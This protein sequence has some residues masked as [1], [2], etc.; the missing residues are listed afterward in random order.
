MAARSLLDSN[1]T[2]LGFSSEQVIFGTTPRMAAVRRCV[3]KVASA[4]VPVLLIGESGTGKD[5]IARYIHDA[6]PW[7]SGAFV[8]INCPAIPG[9]LIESELFGYEQGG[10]TGANTAK[11]GRVELAENGTLFLD[12]ISELDSSVQSKLLQ[13]LQD[14]KFCRIGASEDKQ[15][16]VRLVCA[17]NRNLEQEVNLGN[18]RADLFYRI[19][20]V[21]I[22]LPPLRERSSD[23]PILVQYFL[24][25]YNQQYNCRAKMLSARTMDRLQA[26]NWPG[27]IRELENLV[28]R[29]VIL[30]TEDAISFEP[31]PASSTVDIEIPPDGQVSLK[32]LTKNAVLELE[33]K[34][35]LK[36]LERN[37]GNRKKTAK[38]LNIS[39]RALL[40][41]IREVGVPSRFSS[42]QFVASDAD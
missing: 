5:V 41:K 30:G 12:E 27:N 19:N 37:H 40:Y 7:S 21:K 10:F 15:V 8:K 25:T 4:Q 13:I 32:V 6:S 2:A 24:H 18:F 23:I 9:T 17:T 31:T 42:R 22:S 38:A 20:V 34:I 1:S 16:D 39:Y 3:E 33:K 28:R 26:Y 14:G 36:I 11:P 35:I 29:Y